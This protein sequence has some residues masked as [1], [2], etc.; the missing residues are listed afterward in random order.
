MAAA[1]VLMRISPSP[2]VLVGIWMASIFP[3]DVVATAVWVDMVNDVQ[4]KLELLKYLQSNGILTALSNAR[5]A[6]SGDEG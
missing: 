1:E 3:R 6:E 4:E 2:G 5:Q